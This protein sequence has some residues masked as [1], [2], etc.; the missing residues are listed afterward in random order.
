MGVGEPLSVR[1]GG[2]AGRTEGRGG[3]DEE[4]AGWGTW[5]GGRGRTR[6]E[7]PPSAPRTLPSLRAAPH[8]HGFV[9]G[10]PVGGVGGIRVMPA[11]R[12][13]GGILRTEGC[14]PG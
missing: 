2:R 10:P 4:E 12:V 5:D 8:Q 1:E 9:P 7:F 3:W 11:A 6:E 14:R 13:H